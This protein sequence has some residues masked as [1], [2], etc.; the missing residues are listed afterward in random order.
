MAFKKLKA[1]MGMG[2]ATIETTLDHD[3]VAPG[4]QVTGSVVVKP[5]DVEQEVE[6]L[7]VELSAIVEVEGEDTE[8]E[9]DVQFGTLSLLEGVTLSPGD[10]EQRHE[11]TFDVP[12]ETPFNHVAGTDLPKVRVGVRTKLAISG[13]I[14]PSDLDPLTV[15]ALPLQEQV[16]D[17]LA[18]LGFRLKGADLERAA[19][20]FG[21]RPEL[22]YAPG[23]RW[24]GKI[25]ELEV[26]LVAR[27]ADT[28]E[29]LLQADRR[30]GWVSEGRDEKTGF[31]VTPGQDLAGVLS[32]HLDELA[33]RR[34]GL[35][36]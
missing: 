23:G 4:G 28:V 13:S 11:F 27:G 8:H 16:H 20:P 19:G 25:A 22:E 29:V 10:A 33:A 2:A 18:G 12:F 34:Q 14:D 35:F 32:G 5:G 36:G 26:S 31:T 30:D 17:A 21:I 7:A 3:E 9:T 15:T 24:A 1:R 6:A